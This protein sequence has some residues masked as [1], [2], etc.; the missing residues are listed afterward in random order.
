M[1]RKFLNASKLI[2]GLHFLC[3]FLLVFISF[4]CSNEKKDTLKESDIVADNIMNSV[5][6]N[7]L[8]Q[9]FG[10]L[11]LSDYGFFEQPLKLLKPIGNVLPYDLNTPLFTDYA[12]KKRF[13]YIPQDSLISYREKDPLK[14]P[15]GTVLIKN[16]YYS[17]EQVVSGETM[18][19]ETRLLIKNDG[20]WI[21]LPYIWNSSQNEAYLELTGGSVPVSLV[22]NEQTFEFLVP[23]V[24]QCKSCH[25]SNGKMV[26]IGPTVRQLNR[27]YD[28]P[29]GEMNQLNKLVELGWLKDHPDSDKWPRVARWDQPQNGSLNERARAYLEINCGHCHRSNGPAKNSGLDLTIFASNE[30][31]LGINKSPV[32]AGAGSGDLK[33][34]ILPGNPEESILVYRM[35]SNNPGVRMPELGRS[36]IHTEGLQLIEN[37]IKS[38]D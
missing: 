11:K 6:M 25:E 9:K 19:I 4:Q 15:N 24:L 16:F 13:I 14:F 5:S 36:L 7:P 3:Y 21:A 30:F 1:I 38:M 23:T 28:Y 27:E 29:S 31:S 20:K 32:A 8:Y 22:D 26:P 33:Y 18:I 35:I 2:K 17:Q 34:D 12:S 37:W 10:D